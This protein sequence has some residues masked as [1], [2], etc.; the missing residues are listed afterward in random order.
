M[1]N[2]KISQLLIELYR[3]SGQQPADIFKQW[4][5]ELVNSV[6]P[7]DSGIWVM[8]SVENTVTPHSIY[9]YNQPMEMIEN[10]VRLTSEDPLRDAALK[11]TGTT[12]D[13][14]AVV[15]RNKFIATEVYIEHCQ[16]Y[17]IEQAISTALIDPVTSLF[18]FISFYRADA[19]KPFSEEDRSTKQFLTPH[20]VETYHFNLFSHI[21]SSS[22]P[23][24]AEESNC[25][26]CD[27]KGVLHQ[28]APGFTKILLDEWSDWRGP[29]LP[30]NLDD[31]LQPGDSNA[32]IGKNIVIKAT[33]LNDLIFVRARR[34]N[35]TDNLSSREYEISNYLAD[36]FNYKKI[37]KILNL[38]PSTVNNH[39]SAIYRKLE[40]K[41]KTELSKLFKS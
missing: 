31:L 6:V 28:V 38:S 33:S 3:G 20:L 12:I 10:Y 16:I 29:N 41:N 25:A 36:G 5:M 40:V 32:F 22:Y 17:G 27:A 39:A 37:A 24:Y 4:A 18:S 21:H 26:I 1:L 11:L 23:V 14:F 8:G 2:D 35:Y 9:L 34:K 30:I 13:L 19:N 7:F 15:P